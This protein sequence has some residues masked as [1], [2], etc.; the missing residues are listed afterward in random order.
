MFQGGSRRD[1]LCF[2]DWSAA[3]PISEGVHGSQVPS[4][5]TAVGRLLCCLFVLWLVMPRDFALSFRTMRGTEVLLRD[6]LSGESQ[7]CVSVCHSTL[8]K[9]ARCRS[10]TLAC[11]TQRT[12]DLQG[13]GERIAEIFSLPNC[14]DNSKYMYCGFYLL[15]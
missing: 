4:K 6:R 5:R 9:P 12:K 10:W 2:P 7:V 3:T 1:I 13:G 14:Q 8:A 11:K 15:P